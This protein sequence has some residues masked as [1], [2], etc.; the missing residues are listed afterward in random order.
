MLLFTALPV[1]ENNLQLPRFRGKGGCGLSSASMPLR[2]LA[3]EQC[4]AFA[5]QTW[6]S[7]QEGVPEEGR[8]EPDREG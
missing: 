2:P 8:T 7:A 6:D 3:S 5:G 4:G 1:E